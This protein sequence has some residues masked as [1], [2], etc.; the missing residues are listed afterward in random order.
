M[1]ANVESELDVS[2]KRIN[3][4][5]S[6]YFSINLCKY[7]VFYR[8]FLHCNRRTTELVQLTLFS[9]GASHELNLD[10]KMCFNEM[11][12]FKLLHVFLSNLKKRGK[13]LYLFNF[14]FFEFFS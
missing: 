13:P 14:Y 6:K 7:F 10:C 12:S 4:N 1:T 3:V 11:I 8:F 9:L 5:S 2:I